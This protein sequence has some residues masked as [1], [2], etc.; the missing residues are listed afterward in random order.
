LCI[1]H[2]W[3]LMKPRDIFGLAVRLLGLVF[4]YLGLRAVTP[5]LDLGAIE[6]ASR[7]DL[8]DALLPV[9]FDLAVAWWL[10]GGGLLLRRA[11]PETSKDLGSSTL[12]RESA[13][14]KPNVTQAPKLVDMDKAEEKLA[15]LVE[16]PKAHH[17]A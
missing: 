14:P 10:L 16:K 8:I 4:L 2:G 12:M 11:Y 5:L 1:R 9:A 7:S 13:A 3:T 17:S 15:S 6:T